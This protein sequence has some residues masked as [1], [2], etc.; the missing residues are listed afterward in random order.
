[1]RITPTSALD[2]GTLQFPSISQELRSTLENSAL[3]AANIFFCRRRRVF[4]LPGTKHEAAAFNIDDGRNRPSSTSAL[5]S[6]SGNAQPR[7]SAVTRRHL[8][9]VFA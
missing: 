2:A 4:R 1:M 7:G 8:P 5:K 9:Q 6:L 3:H